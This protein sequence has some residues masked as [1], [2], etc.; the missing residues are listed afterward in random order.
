MGISF[1]LNNYSMRKDLQSYDLSLSELSVLNFLPLF[2]WCVKCLFGLPTDIIGC[3][4]YHRKGYLLFTNLMC[5]ICCWC[6][7]INNL[8]LGPFMS[9]NFLWQVFAA[10]ADVVYDAILTED[11]KM[12]HKDRK[13]KGRLWTWYA[14]AFG[15]LIG[16]T[17]GPSIWDAFGSNCIY[18]I[19]SAVYM[20]SMTISIVV[21]DYPHV[22]SSK[23]TTIV[24]RNGKEEIKEIDIDMRGRTKTEQTQ[25]ED[26]DES[27]RHKCCFQMGLARESLYHPI[28]KGIW[29]FIILT[30]LIPSPGLPLFYFLTDVVGFTPLEMG[31]LAGAG[32]VGRIIGIFVF[33]KCLKP[34]SIRKIYYVLQIFRVLMALVP[35]WLTWKVHL[36]EG[37]VC[38]PTRHN[39]THWGN[40]TCYAYEYYHLDPVP[41]SM[42][43]DC[44]GEVVEEV[45]SMP[46]THL[47]QIVCAATVEATVMAS[48][49]AT[50]NLFSGMRL[51]VD[52]W[53]IMMLGLNHGRYDS[54][55]FFIVFCTVCDAIAILFIQLLPDRTIN[56]IE[57]EVNQQ[58][59]ARTMLAGAFTTQP[60]PIERNVSFKLTDTQDEYLI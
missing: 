30:S 8:L 17:C 15:A 2:P 1:T 10:W 32:E 47:A 53:F 56:D 26:E 29:L 11:R 3:F 51:W 18:A 24:D 48:V 54:L 14:K 50:E 23:I 9:L 42:S 37:E 39:Q 36:G 59:E 4:G 7:M 25:E 49:L 19:L 52:A 6:L 44:I 31:L 16:K 28:L 41:L 13:G 60:D 45:I 5:A 43:D 38:P 27:L 12:E 33:D 35:I 20:L 22:K 58:R 34:Y 21:P 55:P 57:V 46:L 40:D